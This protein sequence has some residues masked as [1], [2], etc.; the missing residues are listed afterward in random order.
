VPPPPGGA[1]GRAEDLRLKGKC[2]EAVPIFRRLATGLG[3][4][5]SKYNLGECLLTLA[6]SDTD[7]AHA[8]GLRKEGADW[9]LHAASAGF[10]QAEKEAATLCADGIGVDKDPVEAD[11]WAIVYHHNAM[12][13]LLGLPDVAPDVR[14]R[15]DAALT[16]GTRAQAEARADAWLPTAA[17]PEN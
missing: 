7:P 1:E 9:I 3:Y 4:A 2:D 5:I 14:D 10:A 17:Q 12:R 11:K 15:I 8:A 6:D 16:S 13:V